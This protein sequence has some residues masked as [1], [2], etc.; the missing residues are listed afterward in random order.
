MSRT[1]ST[2]VTICKNL[3]STITLNDGYTMPMFGLGM[4]LS[5]SGS[6]ASA[7]RA[8]TYALKNGYKL[9]DTAEFYGNE[10]DV[11]RGIKASGLRRE[12]Y[13]VVTKV[14]TNGAD[15]C[16]SAF[17]TSL[18][19]LD[20]GYIDLYLIHSPGKGKIVETYKTMMDFQKQGLVKSIGVSNFGVHHL[21]GMKAAGL[22]TPTVNQIE[23]H[24]WMKKKDIVQYCRANNIAVM[25]YS[26]LV[27][28]QRFNEPSLVEVA[29]RLGR[30]TAEVLIRYSVQMGYITI[31]KSD[32]PERIL[33]NTS[34]FEW[35]I[36]QLDMDVLNSFPE[37]S[38]T[39]NPCLFPWNG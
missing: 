2:M 19:K 7:E 33:G 39:W 22:P 4:Y 17:T 21:E 28:G 12:E 23:L 31:P 5:K 14:W 37:S 3:S 20:I 35:E 15:V 29:E 1:L 8:V 24:P 6:G 30:T 13:F 38:C 36:P 9:I 11:G 18:K 27:K 32:K 10:S 26:P 34:V 25:G 16:R